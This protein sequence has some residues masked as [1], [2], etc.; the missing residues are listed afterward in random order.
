[1]INLRNGSF[2]EKISKHKPTNRAA[3]DYACINLLYIY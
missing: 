3:I 1:M 2:Y